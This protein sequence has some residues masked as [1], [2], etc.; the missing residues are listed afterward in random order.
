M[1]ALIQVT[2]LKM[3]VAAYSRVVKSIQ[4]LRTTSK[5]EIA[6]ARLEKN[7]IE[8]EVERVAFCRSKYCS[9]IPNGVKNIS[10][11]VYWFKTKSKL[12]VDLGQRSQKATELI[13]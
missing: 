2:L 1:S 12:T 7:K 4:W 9:M 3:R 11:W 5:S 6:E 13:D 8:Q 10:I